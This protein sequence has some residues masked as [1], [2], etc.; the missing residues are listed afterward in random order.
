M[1]VMA[2]PMVM[3]P[4]VGW[5]LDL[6]WHGAVIDGSKI[7][8]FSAYRYGFSLMLVWALLSAILVLFTKETY[9]QQ[10]N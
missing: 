3:Q 4:A 2:G 5:I 9:C 1:G 7:Y 8:S 6:K 10:T